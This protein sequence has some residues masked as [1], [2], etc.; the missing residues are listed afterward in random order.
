MP[1][2]AFMLVYN[3]A[4]TLSPCWER[5]QIGRAQRMAIHENRARLTRSRF[6]LGFMDIENVVIIYDELV[7]ETD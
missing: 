4:L 2:L 3:Q 6:T 5:M 1:A 7:L